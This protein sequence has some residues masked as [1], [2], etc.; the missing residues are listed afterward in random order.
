[1]KMNNE[2]EKKLSLYLKSEARRAE[3]SSEWWD[4]VIINLESHRHSSYWSRLIPRTRLAWIAFFF[5]CFIV[6]GGVVCGAT[7][8]IRGFFQQ[9]AGHIENVG[10]AQVMDLRRTIDGVTV[11]LERVYADANI[12]IV[13]YTVDGPEMTYYVPS[14]EI[15]T[16][17][18]IALQSIQ[19]VMTVPEDISVMDTWQPSGCMAVIAMFDSSS[20]DVSSQELK[21]R[22]FIKIEKPQKSSNILSD[23][24]KIID[25]FVF[26]IAVPFNGGKTISIEQV[27]ETN[28]IIMKL[29]KVVISRWGAR[30]SLEI[31]D[32]NKT[33]DFSFLT[34][35]DKATID[36]SRDFSADSFG[37]LVR[38][39]VINTNTLPVATMI[40][41]DGRS[42]KTT[43]VRTELSKPDTFLI[44][45]SEDLTAQSGEWVLEVDELIIPVIGS[46]IVSG[47]ETMPAPYHLSGPWRFRFW[48][49]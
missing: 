12:V 16:V 42:I 24:D 40:L 17:N 49:P 21:L 8:I 1:M 28:G 2:I 29:D 46:H 27:V 14:T 23:N 9:Y 22:V 32:I 20:L 44:Y 3:P 11:K 34:K 10:L 30:I 25:T 35:P 41:P 45:F 48:V 38:D 5:L 39:F 31:Y 6:A 7:T 19:G 13:G 4:K 33:N 36:S 26:N 43:F 18:G 15:L 37:N 47:N